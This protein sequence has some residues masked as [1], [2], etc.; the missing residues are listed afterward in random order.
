MPRQLSRQQC[1]RRTEIISH[2]GL[3]LR[4]LRA[5]QNIGFPEDRCSGVRDRQ[6]W[7]CEQETPKGLVKRTRLQA[8]AP[9]LGR[10]MPDPEAGASDSGP[11]TLHYP[12]PEERVFARL[13]GWP[14]CAEIQPSR[15]RARGA[16]PQGEDSY[17]G[18]A[19]PISTRVGIAP[20]CRNIMR[21]RGFGD[22]RQARFFQFPVD[23][24][25]GPVGPADHG[26]SAKG[27]RDC[28][29]GHRSILLNHA[30]RPLLPLSRRVRL[31]AIVFCETKW[32]SF[33]FDFRRTDLHIARKRNVKTRISPRSPE[34]RAPKSLHPASPR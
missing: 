28:D 22:A 1:A 13:E 18:S 32:R 24:K 30:S 7:D 16:A 15:R 9:V 27:T 3:T 10:V 12:H 20:Q 29:N 2:Q 21:P 25:R 17:S 5:I 19:R 11:L 14:P 23:L 26:Q 8:C 33:C 4:E 6:R 31:A 34:F